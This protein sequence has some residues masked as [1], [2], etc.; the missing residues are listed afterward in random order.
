MAKEMTFLT[1]EAN[2]ISLLSAFKSLNKDS[3]DSY[4]TYYAIKIRNSELEDL[5]ILVDDLKALSKNIALFDKFFIGYSIPQ[6]G[7]EF[8]LLRIDKEAVVNIELKKKSTKEKIIAQLS[9]NKYY[10][11]F[12]KR[13][14]Y[15]CTYVADEKNCIP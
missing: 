3:F 6:I 5:Q 11:S 4:L 7:K 1:K 14:T 8:D 12:L 10:L 15:C 9:K 2:L 13:N